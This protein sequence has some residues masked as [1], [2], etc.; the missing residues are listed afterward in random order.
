MYLYIF[1][2]TYIY[3]YTQR[4]YI[5]TYICTLLYILITY[6]WAEHL[7]VTASPHACG[8]IM[9]DSNFDLLDV[10]LQM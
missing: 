9:F 6:K 3:I 2:Q 10:T 7:Q 4:N 8:W 1:S 5:Y